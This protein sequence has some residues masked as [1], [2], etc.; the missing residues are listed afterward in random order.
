MPNHCMNKL[1]VSGD[2]EKRALFFESMK[3]TADGKEIL[4]DLGK[5]LP[6]PSEFTQTG[7]LPGWLEWRNKNWGTK[8]GCYSAHVKEDDNS[9]VYRFRTAHCPFKYSL[10]R[11]M[12]QMYPD[13]KFTLFYAERTMDFIG[14]YTQTSNWYMEDVPLKKW[15]NT[16]NAKLDTENDDDEYTDSNFIDDKYQEWQELWYI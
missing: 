5:I 3:S 1:I 14:K 6:E 12:C 13:L 4:L 11:K 10:F 9:M 16:R 8:W 7:V 2:A 15:N